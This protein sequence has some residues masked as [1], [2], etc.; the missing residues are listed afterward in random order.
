MY[1]IY[2]Y[3]Y[4]HIY[5]VGRPKYI[6]G[7]E[8]C[9]R[10]H[11]GSIIDQELHE[12]AMAIKAGRGRPRRSISSVKQRRSQKVNSIIQNDILASSVDKSM[13]CERT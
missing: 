5:I 1:N 11:S 13:H 6:L 12:Q 4:I 2:I 9:S 3:I 7:L 8:P 10:K